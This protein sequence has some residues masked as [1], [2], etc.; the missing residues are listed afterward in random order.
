MDEC[1]EAGSCA[2]WGQLLGSENSLPAALP[3]LFLGRRAGIQHSRA[4]ILVQEPFQALC[5]G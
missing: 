3:V 2:A 1:G 5:C 4:E